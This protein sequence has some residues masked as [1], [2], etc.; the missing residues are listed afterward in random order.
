MNRR[1]IFKGLLGLSTIAVAGNAANKELEAWAAKNV[2][3]CRRAPIKK[4][5][6]SY[7]LH[8]VYDSDGR[9]YDNWLDNHNKDEMHL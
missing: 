3:D 5:G 4:E 2:I 1:D 6:G 7:N 9:E 8:S